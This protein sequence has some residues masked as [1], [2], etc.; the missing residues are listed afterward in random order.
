MRALPGISSL[1]VRACPCA[2]CWP[3]INN[4]EE[5][6]HISLIPFAS[7]QHLR[8]II[9]N[10]ILLVIM[11]YLNGFFNVTLD[12]LC[13]A[14]TN[15]YPRQLNVAWEKVLGYSIEELEGRRFIDFIHENDIEPTNEVL[16]RLADQI[17]VIGF[18]NRYRCKDGTY[19]W[20]EW[21]SAPKGNI[22]YSAARDI[23]EKK[24]TN[25]RLMESD[26]RFRNAI[27]NSNDGVHY[28]HHRSA[29]HPEEM[30]NEESDY[31]NC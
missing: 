24:E 22:I 4:T 28:C 26:A 13:I 9:Q 14:D 20:L 3:A 1:P 10:A 29:R 18:I 17:E 31:S 11:K 25:E 15:G 23:I 8:Y 6:P 12:L 30:E 16:S 19:R 21:R 5:H 27:E 7:L 2:S